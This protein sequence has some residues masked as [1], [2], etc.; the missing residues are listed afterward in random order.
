[1]PRPVRAAPCA[2]SADWPDVAC[3]DP[4]AEV[5]RLLALRVRDALG[6]RSLRAAGTLT[7]V[8]HTTIGDV[9]AGRV[10]ADVA[11]LARLEA[12]LGSDLWPGRGSGKPKR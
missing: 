6:G 8:D 9:L 1:M 2:H 7:G 3:D 10:W 11:T 4:V 12:G 5:A